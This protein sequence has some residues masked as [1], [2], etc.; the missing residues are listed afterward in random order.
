MQIMP[1]GPNDHLSFDPLDDTKLWPVDQ[2]P[3]LPCGRMVLDRVPDNFF[4]EVEQ[5]AFGTGV[6][7]DGI[8]VAFA[9]TVTGGA[10]S[11][12]MFLVYLDVVA[13]TLVASYRTGIRDR[14]STRLNSSHS[15]QSRM[16]SSA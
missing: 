3:L 13:V 1:D 6:L 7:V 12:L 16:P 4:A 14:K 10:G 11:P 8:V 5:S 15:Q 2:F 9:V